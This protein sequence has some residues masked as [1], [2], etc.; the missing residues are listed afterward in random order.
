MPKGDT[1]K[2]SGMTINTRHISTKC[3]KT[4]SGTTNKV[5][6]LIKLHMKVCK[7]CVN[8][9]IYKGENAFTRQGLNNNKVRTQLLQLKDNINL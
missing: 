6:S 8:A 4:Y 1:L 7:I 3:G 9:V 5:D 2:K